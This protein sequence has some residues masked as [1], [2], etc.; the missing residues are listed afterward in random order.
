MQRA[1]EPAG[2]RFKTYWLPKLE[3]LAA[4]AIAVAALSLTHIGCPIRFLFGV[5]CP[6]CGITRACSAFLHG[7]FAEAF[8]WHPLFL[9][10]VPAFVYISVGDYPLLGSPKRETAFC[11]ALGVLLFAVYIIR[12]FWGEKFGL[13]SIDSGEG[14]VIKLIKQ[15]IMRCF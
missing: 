5:P 7:H 8:R 4:I 1:A 10:A 15:I 14:V 3:V 13:Y 6:G 9:I 11:V 2:R 12:L